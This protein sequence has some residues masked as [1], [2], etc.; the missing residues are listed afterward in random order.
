MSIYLRKIYKMLTLKYG[1][2]VPGMDAPFTHEL[3]DGYF[4]EKHWD[5]AKHQTY[6]VWDEKRT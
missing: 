2:N 1:A 5:P 6:A 3:T 4:Q